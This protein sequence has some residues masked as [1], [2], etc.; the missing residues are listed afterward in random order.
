MKGAPARSR[1]CSRHR[2]EVT[3]HNG[4]SP[5][6]GASPPV[7]TGDHSTDDVSCRFS[8]TRESKRCNREQAA[9]AGDIIGTQ[10]DGSPDRTG[11]HGLAAV[12]VPRP[13]VPLL[14]IAPPPVKPMPVISPS[15]APKRA[16]S[17]DASGKPAQTVALVCADAGCRCLPTTDGR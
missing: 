17:T 4:R 15:T 14:T 11:G 10:A 9:D 6:F 16:S 13:W 3:A 7:Q 2:C 5:G 8:G 12:V 1:G